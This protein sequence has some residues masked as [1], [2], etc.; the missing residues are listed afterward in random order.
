MLGQFFTHEL[1]PLE[2]EIVV[3]EVGIG[4]EANQ[5]YRIQYD[6]TVMDE[7]AYCCIGGD[8]DAVRER[9][10]DG[11]D[12]SL[13]VDAAIR[14]ARRALAGDEREISAADPRGCGA[15]GDRARCVS[16]STLLPASRRRR[17]GNRPRRRR[18]RCGRR[19]G[20]SGRFLIRQ[21]EAKPWPE[22]PV[23]PIT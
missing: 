3:V 19:R 17:S 11:Y 21:S 5:L 12:P 1:K 4:G 2:V 22:R 16:S 23:S 14:L 6:G 7:E 20:R 15:G 10:A 13:D 8:A 18:R 9:V